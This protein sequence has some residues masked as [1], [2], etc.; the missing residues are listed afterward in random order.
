MDKSSRNVI[1]V[2]TIVAV[3]IGVWAVYD[4]S[5]GGTYLGFSVNK[6]DSPTIGVS[7]Q[8][9]HIGDN[10]D[11][12]INWLCWEGETEC[13]RFGPRPGYSEQVKTVARL[14]NQAGESMAVSLRLDYQDD[15][16]FFLKDENGN[17][18]Q[19]IKPVLGPGESMMVN[20]A[21][22]VSADKEYSSQAKLVISEGSSQSVL[23]LE[24]SVNTE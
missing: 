21:F 10:G 23:C 17:S 3:I 2:F 5:T 6:P 9:E 18:A 11:L 14:E 1:V 20:V 7:Y 16:T 24:G 22:Y 8:P 15:W 13:C 19:E 4:Y 12:K